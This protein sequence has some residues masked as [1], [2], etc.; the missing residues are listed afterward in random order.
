MDAVVRIVLDAA[1]A[2]V[3]NR[4]GP[5]TN[6]AAR[7]AKGGVIRVTW[8]RP[9][10]GER[11]SYYRIYATATPGPM[12]W[13]TPA[14]TVGGLDRGGSFSHDL[15]GLADGTAYLIGVRAV[16]ATG[17]EANSATV[18]AVSDSSGPEPVVA[19]AISTDPADW[20]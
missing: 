6:L 4:P 3:T 2:D 19:L 9:A 16:N 8:A 14:A 18:S 20:S 13:T 12:A 15:T 7:T 11:A 1:G 5:P 10:T 17:E